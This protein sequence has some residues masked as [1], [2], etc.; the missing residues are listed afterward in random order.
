[1]MGPI[2]C[3]EMSVRYYEDLLHHSPE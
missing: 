1:M 3:P 2:G